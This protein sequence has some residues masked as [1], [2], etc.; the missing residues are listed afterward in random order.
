MHQ[1]KCIKRC[2]LSWMVGW[3]FVIIYIFSRQ[4]QVP[5]IL[6]KKGWC[7][8]CCKQ[9]NNPSRIKEEPHSAELPVSLHTEPLAPQQADGARPITLCATK[10]RAQLENPT[11]WPFPCLGG[12]PIEVLETSPADWEGRRWVQDGATCCSCRCPCSLQG[13]WTR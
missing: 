4:D 1:T 12:G 5:A 2:C 13:S 3:K 7:P 11:S 10:L 8:S 6:S 9:L